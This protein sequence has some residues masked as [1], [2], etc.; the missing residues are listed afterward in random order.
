[1][2]RQCAIL[3]GCL[4]L[5]ELVV[6]LTGIKLPSSIIGMLFLTLFLRLGWIKLHWVQGMSDFLVANL[7][8]FFI[9]PGV[10]LMCYLDIIQAQFWPIVIATLI[11]TIVVLVITGWVHQLMRKI[12]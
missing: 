9:P 11:S 2:I 5:G 1:M 12:K 8:F 6:Y 4:A 10:A 7:G 3:F